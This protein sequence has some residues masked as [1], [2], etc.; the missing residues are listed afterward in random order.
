M[1]S[2]RWLVIAITMATFMTAT[3]WGQEACPCVPQTKLWIATVCETWNCASSALV[4][5]NGDPA[6]FA[7]PLRF[8]DP[9]WLL[10]QQV[11][12]GAHIDN[13]P[14]E[15]ERFDGIGEAAARLASIPADH[16]P[17]IVTAP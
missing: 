8:R 5:A 4:A 6:V 15:V 10:I 17:M 11:S 13:S 16:R 7:I 2:T 14:F 12:G 3:G 9:R 1:R